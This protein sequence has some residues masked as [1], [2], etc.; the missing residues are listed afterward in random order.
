MHIFYSFIFVY[1]QAG[2]KEN[3]SRKMKREMMFLKLWKT[4]TKTLPAVVKRECRMAGAYFDLESGV[5]FGDQIQIQIK[6]KGKTKQTK[7]FSGV[8][9]SSNTMRAKFKIDKIS[10]LPRWKRMKILIWISIKI[11]NKNHDITK[12][13]RG[14]S[15]RSLLSECWSR[16][17]ISKLAVG[18]VPPRVSW[19]WTLFLADSNRDW[20][21]KSF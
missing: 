16:S 9:F 3:R 17:G 1:S 18:R 12:S 21:K 11:P 13:I 5:G 7:T 4:K 20:Y 8:S 10:S 6:S 19:R 15:Q 2:G 14:A